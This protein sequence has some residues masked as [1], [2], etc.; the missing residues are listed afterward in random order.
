MSETSQRHRILPI[1]VRA[2]VSLAFIALGIGIYAWLYW[3]RPQPPASDPTT[4][5]RLRLLVTEPFQLEVG[6]H[7]RAFGQAQARDAADVPARVTAPVVTV[8]PNYREGAV[9]AAGEPLVTL[10]ASDFERQLAIAD[11]SLKTIEAQVSMLNLDR[12]SLT[13]A[14]QLAEEDAKIAADDL[15]RVRRAAAQD[16][17]VAR[18]VD[19]ARGAAIAAERAIIAARDATL[20]LPLRAASLEAERARQQA[21]RELAKLSLERSTIVSPI[22]GIVQSADLEIGEVAAPGVRVARVVDPSA[23]EIPILLP[24]GARRFVAV[25]DRVVLRADRADAVEVVAR[26][27]RIAPEDDASTRT[28]T[29]YAEAAGSNELPP[30]AFVEAEVSAR[31]DHARTV[32]PRRAVSGGRINVVRDGA[33]HGL[34]VIVE[35]SF[36]GSPS[37]RLPDTEWSVL[38]EPLPADTLIVLDGSRRLRE[39]APVT[40]V[41]PGVEADSELVGDRPAAS[42]PPSSPSSTPPSTPS[43]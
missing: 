39:G 16:A 8:H 42:T 23:I 15:E 2:V 24:A 33:V 29:V 3:T 11:E 25:G 34:E 10:D 35:F 27:T 37:P 7:Y 18:E 38:S 12:G 4:T 9:V 28:M 31:A 17:A 36:T 19:R 22:A 41:K 43:P 26:I 14:L 32:V 13:R 6:R 1:L 5:G 40:A 21:S 30:G 20:K